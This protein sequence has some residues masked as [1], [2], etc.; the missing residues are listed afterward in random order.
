MF[1]LLFRRF[2]ISDTG[3]GVTY[4]GDVARRRKNRNPRA[5]FAPQVPSTRESENSH[6]HHALT[7][8]L[9]YGYLYAQHT[10]I[11]GAHSK[12]LLDKDTENVFFSDRDCKERCDSRC[13]GA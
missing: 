7:T 3:S 12:T 1:I 8:P 11:Y 13:F 6:N 2:H 9:K 5:A 4:G 10:R